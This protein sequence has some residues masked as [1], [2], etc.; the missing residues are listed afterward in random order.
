MKRLSAIR[1]VVVEEKNDCDDAARWRAFEKLLAD[2][3]EK[4]LPPP[5]AEDAY[6]FAKRAVPA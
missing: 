1:E 5:N 6:K 4:K 2:T 3:A